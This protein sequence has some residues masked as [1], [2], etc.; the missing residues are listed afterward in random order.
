M[1]IPRYTLQPL[2]ALVAL[3]L[4]CVNP[5]TSQPIRSRQWAAPREVNDLNA[6]GLWTTFEKEA[7]TPDGRLSRAE[8]TLVSDTDSIQL[9]D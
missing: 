9:L 8:H 7:S 1:A 6:R 5:V 2:W 3:V 4:V